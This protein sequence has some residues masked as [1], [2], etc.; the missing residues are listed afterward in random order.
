ME[1]CHL[2]SFFVEA[3]LFTTVMVKVS[4][5]QLC[6]REDDD[7]C[8]V[9]S[10]NGTE[11][12][13]K[14]LKGY[15][16]N[17]CELPCRYPG[18]GKLCQQSC[19]CEEKNCNHI[20]GCQ[21]GSPTIT[22][23]SKSA[24]EIDR[25]LLHEDVATK[26]ISCPDGFTGNNCEMPCRFPSYGYGCQPKCGCDQINC[27]HIN[28]CNVSLTSC[29]SGGKSGDNNGTQAMLYSTVI[30]SVWAIIQLGIYLYISLM[31]TPGSRFIKRRT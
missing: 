27:N 21:N 25:S 22:P 15:M 11:I 23:N 31:F 1:T 4:S 16:G 18:Y 3:F 19:N 8:W 10:T 5:E 20:T 29:N 6:I 26:K 12:C 2:V 28:G 9:R 24:T 14:C 17:K 30:L 13:S 7:C